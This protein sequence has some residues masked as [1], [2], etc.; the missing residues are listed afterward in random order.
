MI[1]KIFSG[2]YIQ[3][4]LRPAAVAVELGFAISIDELPCDD[5]GTFGN[6]S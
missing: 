1:C 3:P 4:E 5:D 6:E 2:E